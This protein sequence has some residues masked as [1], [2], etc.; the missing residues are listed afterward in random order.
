MALF[1]G[2]GAERGLEA[3][4]VHE[5]LP[6]DFVAS[7]LFG[8]VKIPGREAV[9]F[10]RVDLS[11]VFSARQRLEELGLVVPQRG[12]DALTGLLGQTRNALRPATG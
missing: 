11:G 7:A 4:G 3:F 2:G 8:Q 12:Q 5:L 9:Q 6:G 10:S 1:G